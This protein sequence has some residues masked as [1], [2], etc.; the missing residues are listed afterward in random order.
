MNEYLRLLIFKLIKMKKLNLLALLIGALSIICMTSCQKEDDLKIQE[1]T[2]TSFKLADLKFND[3]MIVFKNDIQVREF[4]TVYNEDLKNEL[5]RQFPNLKSYQERFQEIRT[6][7]KVTGMLHKEDKKMI[8]QKFILGEEVEKLR[9]ILALGSGIVNILN[10]NATFKVGD[11]FVQFRE[12]MLFRSKEISFNTFQDK[13]TNSE[14]EGTILHHEINQNLNSRG[15]NKVDDCTKYIPG[16]N[17]RVQGDLG[18]N[19]LNS[20]GY[21]LWGNSNYERKSFFH[22]RDQTYNK[23]TS[24]IVIIDS[25]GKQ[26]YKTVSKYNSDDL[27]WAGIYIQTY[28]DAENR[29]WK[30]VDEL[31]DNFRCRHY[32]NVTFNNRTYN[33]ACDTYHAF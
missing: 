32:A 10:E 1:K 30:H 28:Y 4:L 31:V 19:D 26:R 25:N 24:H 17:R 7:W 12:D 27:V 21:Y 6:E 18:W 23:C 16:E 8:Q 5:K 22:W 13:I 29:R 20:F 33:L 15:R 2:T 14:L 3:G 9:P 11:E